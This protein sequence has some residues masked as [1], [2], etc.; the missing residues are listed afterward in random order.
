MSHDREGV[1]P[2]HRTYTQRHRSLAVAALNEAEFSQSPRQ[3][4]LKR[5]RQ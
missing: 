2:F 5:Y 4:A 3:R 1:V